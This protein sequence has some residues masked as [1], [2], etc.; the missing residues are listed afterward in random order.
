MVRV[1][2]VLGGLALVVIAVE[3]GLVATGAL[4]FGSAARLVIALELCL[5][6]FVILEVVV[7]AKAV[8]SARTQGVDLPV[9]L[10]KSLATFLPGRVARYL[11]QDLMLVRAIFMLF[12]GRRDVAEDEQP[13][14]YSGPLVVMLVA[15]T[16]A[17]GIVAILLHQLLPADVRN[18]AL[19]L[20]VIGLVWLTGFVSSLI[21]Y[22]H[23][24]S[25]DRLRLRFS[26]FHDLA[27]STAAIR[28]VRTTSHAPRTQKAAERLDDEVVMVVSGQ[29]NIVVDLDATDVF[30]L[31]PSV[32][33]AGTL[34]RVSFYANQPSQVRDLLASIATA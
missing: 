4:D 8:R 7:V 11:R 15:L 23:V 22:P 6:V 20:G 25:A 19:V 16:V 29:A 5:S 27:V 32:S 21:C 14:A 34:R 10:D 3:V 13:I 18:V 1:R 12:T 33:D 2:K 31:N 24:V 30:S 9:A 17:D 28:S 26:A